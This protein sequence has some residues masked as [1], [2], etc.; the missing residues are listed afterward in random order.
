MGLVSMVPT[1]MVLPPIAD[2]RFRIADRSSA[3]CNPKSSLDSHG[4]SRVAFAQQ[5]GVLVD[6]AEKETLRGALGRA[7]RPQSLIHPIFAIVALDDLAVARVELD[8][9]P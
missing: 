6:V 1:F 5:G 2:C 9:A 4:L 7:R 8:R 3:I